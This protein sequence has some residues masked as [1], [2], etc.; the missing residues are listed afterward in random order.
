M[1]IDLKEIID[2]QWKLFGRV[3]PPDLAADKPLLKKS[4][5]ELNEI[6]NRVMHPI[7]GLSFTEDEFATVRQLHRQLDAKRWRDSAESEPDT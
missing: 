6:R 5:Q 4:L 7:K 1:F 2:K 3:L